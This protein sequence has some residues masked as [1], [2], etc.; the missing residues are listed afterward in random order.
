M[1]ECL[2]NSASTQNRPT[3]LAQLSKNHTSEV[4]VCAQISTVLNP[5]YADMPRPACNY[6]CE[7]ARMYRLVLESHAR[8]VLERQERARLLHSGLLDPL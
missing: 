4:I 7:R 8:G 3:C 1:F 5:D 6:H 2:H